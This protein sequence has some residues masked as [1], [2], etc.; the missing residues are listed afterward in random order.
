MASYTQVYVESG[1][2]VGHQE[3]CGCCAETT[4]LDESQL[5]DYIKDLEEEIVKARIALTE[6]FGEVS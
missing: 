6:V 3:G 2:V 5:R 4:T 1:K